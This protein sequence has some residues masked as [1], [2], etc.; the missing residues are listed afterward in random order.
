MAQLDASLIL[1]GRA[2]QFENPMDIASK[3]MNMRQLANSNMA[4]EKKAANEAALNASMK[5]NVV[6]G[7]DGKLSLNQQGVVQDLYKDNPQMAMEQQKQ[8][9]GHDLEKLKTDTGAMKM[10]MSDAT[11]DNWMQKKSQAL[12]LGITN[13]DKLPDKVTDQDITGIK[14]R[15]LDMDK[16]IDNQLNQQKFQF[17]QKEHNDKMALEYSKLNKEKHD[18]DKL[19]NKS[20]F[21]AAGFGRRIEQSEAIFKKLTENGYD[22]TSFGSSI[23]ASSMFPNAMRGDGVEQDQA[24]RNF[25]NA[26][27]RRESGAAISPTE[28]SSAESQYFPRNGDNDQVLANKLANRQQVM[29]S[30]KAE[31][32][33]SWEKVP[34]VVAKNAK[35]EEKKSPLKFDLDVLDYAKKNNVTPEQALIFKNSYKPP[36]A[37]N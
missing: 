20:Q 7:P 37:G 11:A 22:R 35:N 4:F 32:G 3:A 33:P 29:E 6:A 8:F 1:Q 16:Q 14:T 23:G 9:E 36:T 2:P 21:D 10:L 25:V 13:A 27:L 18:K 26:V 34:L 30:L 31:A 28:F 19:G 24:E 17:S 5:K 12:K 15:T